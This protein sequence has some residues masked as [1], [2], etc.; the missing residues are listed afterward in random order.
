MKRL[1]LLPVAIIIHKM[2]RTLLRLAYCLLFTACCLLPTASVKA[3]NAD[4]IHVSHYNISIDTIN[5]TAHTLR[6]VTELTVHSKV[7]GLGT[8]KLDLDTLVV[9][10]IIAQAA[11]L[12][13]TH[14]NRM[15]LLITLPA[16]MNTSD[17]IVMKVY[18]HG[19]PVTDP[20][21]FGGFYFNGNYAYN[22]GVALYQQPHNF[23]KTWFPCVDEFTDRATYEFHITTPSTY[24]A[25]CNGTL[26]D[27]TVNANG[28]L[29]WNWHFNQTMPTYLAGISAA[30]FY[31]LRRTYQG[32][33]VQ[34]AIMPAD[35]NKTINFFNKLDT[36]L[37]GYLDRYGTYPFDKVGYSFVPF[38]AGGMEHSSCIHMGTAFVTVTLQY[39]YI[40]Y[41]ELSH[42]W[43][44]D[45]VTCKTAEDMWLNEG[46]ALFNENYYKTWT[47]ANGAAVRDSQLHALHKKVVQVTHVQD[48]GYYALNNVPQVHT[49]GNTVYEK[50]GV[51]ANKIRRF[52]GENLFFSSV[53]DYLNNRAWQS[54]TS[55]DLRSELQNS[56]GINMVDFFNTCVATPGFPHVSVDSFTVVPNGGNYDVTVYTR[57]RQKGNSQTFA[58]Q[59]D[60]TFADAVTDTTVEVTVNAPTNS[61]TVT[62]PFIPSWISADRY[63][64][65][66]SAT[67][68][69]ERTVSNNATYTF[70][71]VN[72]SVQV[73]D[74][75]SAAGSVIRIEHNYVR[76][77]GNNP[78]GIRISDYRYY[79]VDGLFNSGLYAKGTF[80]Y[81]G[82][83]SLSN[84]YLD[85]TLIAGSATED[86]LV[87]LYRANP[88]EN[89]QVVNGYAINFQVSHT[90][91]RGLITVDTLKRGEYVLGVRDYTVNIPDLVYEGNNLRVSPN[92]SDG[93]VR[94]AFLLNGYKG[95]IE[96]SDARGRKVYST[97]VFSHQEMIDWDSYKVGPGLYLIR[98]IDNGELTGHQ[99]VVI[100]RK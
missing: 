46:W 48:N 74:T 5:Y 19:T 51:V 50:G 96:I 85:N 24:K 12:S 88:G 78:A 23:G 64:K 32:I 16:V 52:M 60:L 53:R 4:T 72:A 83:V 17:S 44:G 35:S 1:L 45:K 31:T 47:S 38:N 6:G 25:F 58:L 33:P 15:A 82:S 84:G 3:N 22:I 62:L 55:D 56:S 10:S 43:F 90:D 97:D 42:M 20:G 94:I 27:S 66:P 68:A 63:E 40:A 71:D 9:D 99:K 49:Y 98:L 39:E 75:G 30:P 59:V 95:T 54:V 76:P 11:S 93:V 29:T 92:P 2:K 41:H 67:L 21:G 57:E 80:N 61:F 34:M 13:F 87:I 37:A 8:V 70:P 77:T 73:I 14:L 65:L 86:S 79:K 81:D 36:V 28:T 100:R 7:N 18:Y 26:Q 69:Y 91:K 89:W